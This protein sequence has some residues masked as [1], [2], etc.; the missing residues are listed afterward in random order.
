MATNCLVNLHAGLTPFIGPLPM[1]FLG[2][3]ATSR[4]G[5]EDLRFL[6]GAEDLGVRAAA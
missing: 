2:P 6:E 3:P 5:D 4:G 1:L